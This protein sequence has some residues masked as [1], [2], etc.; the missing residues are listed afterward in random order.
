MCSPS[1][2][3]DEVRPHGRTRSPFAAVTLVTLV[4]Q[5]Q[6]SPIHHWWCGEEV[7]G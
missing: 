2:P 6:S 4:G 1:P 3:D 5:A 7:E